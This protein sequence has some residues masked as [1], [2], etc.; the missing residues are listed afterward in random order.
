MA[1]DTN[2]DPQ[3]PTHHTPSPRRATLANPTP[4][5]TLFD[6][7][8]TPG[9]DPGE[10]DERRNSRES[11]NAAAS[12]P[13]DMLAAYRER[14]HRIFM[15]E[16]GLPA[17]VTLTAAAVDSEQEIRRL[18]AD[19]FDQARADR[20]AL[21]AIGDDLLAQVA[22]YAGALDTDLK[23]DAQVE[24]TFREEVR[25]KAL[26]VGLDLANPMYAARAQRAAAQAPALTAF[27]LNQEELRT[28]AAKLSTPHIRAGRDLR[29]IQAD[30]AE[31]DRALAEHAATRR[32]WLPGERRREWDQKHN[33]LH[34]TAQAAHSRA[35]D[36]RREHP[37]VDAAA[38][39][40]DQLEE[41]REHLFHHHHHLLDA[42]VE[43]K[44]GQ[45]PEWLQSAIGIQPEGLDASKWLRVA[46]DL[47][48]Y[49]LLNGVADDQDLDITK[50]TPGLLMQLAA[51][52]PDTALS[53]EQGYGYGR[54]VG[55]GI[56]M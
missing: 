49:R 18:I 34:T 35:Q 55:A 53:Q 5:P 38:E 29:H 52:Q 1:P 17:A 20:A 37:G 10:N 15:G 48:S 45:E 26:E 23:E 14:A 3:H 50:A 21:T 19:T 7:D 43:E 51:Y 41:R 44:I 30:A 39:E 28:V 13:L 12:I 32:P 8:L 22:D 56:S 46:K 16:E 47:T 6:L 4:I 36:L 24:Q 11:A 42:A 31:K 2:A 33:E 54:Q 25:V 27:K 40:R 9:Q